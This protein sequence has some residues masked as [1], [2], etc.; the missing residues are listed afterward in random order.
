MLEAL[1]EGR[2]P[3]TRFE[4]VNAAMTAINSHVVL[5]I[6]RDCA[7]EDGDLWVIYMGNN[8][9]VGPF[10][11]GTVFGSPAANL[12]LIRTSLALKSLRCGQLLDQLLSRLAR[13]ATYSKEWG[14]MA[15]F[16]QHLVREDDPRMKMVY[17]HFDQ[18]LRELLTVGRRHGVKVLVGTVASNLKDC[19]PFASVHRPGLT[20]AR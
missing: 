13:H 8:E 10:G 15:M 17:S 20:D 1:L 2:Y 14:G 4:V 7:R 9:V 12:P 6:G 5:P 16:L 11:A 18:N 3:G 19:A